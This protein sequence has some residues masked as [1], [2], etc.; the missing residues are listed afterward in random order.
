[1]P[2]APRQAASAPARQAWPDA[3]PARAKKSDVDDV[4]PDNDAD[5]DSDGL[6]GLALLQKELG[7]RVIQEIDHS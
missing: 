7:G 2:P 5:V 4:D 6:S 1:A 3:V